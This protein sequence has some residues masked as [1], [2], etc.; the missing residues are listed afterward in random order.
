MKKK[1]EEELFT[2]RSHKK[3][4][5]MKETTVK[6][7]R[8]GSREKE[9]FFLFMSLRI[10]EKVLHSEFELNYSRIFSLPHDTKELKPQF[11]YYFMKEENVMVTLINE[12]IA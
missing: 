3:L 4:L 9:K 12:D 7:L 2:R 1:E 6:T 5:A 8:H 11:P 10:V